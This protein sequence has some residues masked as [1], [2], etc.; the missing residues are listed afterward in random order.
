M[1]D[2]TPASPAREST[3]DSRAMWSLALKRMS[4]A[5]AL[6]DQSNAPPEIGAELDLAINR[7]QAAIDRHGNAF[8]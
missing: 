4:E 7:L 5:L 3:P 2:S 1:N 6:L 8:E